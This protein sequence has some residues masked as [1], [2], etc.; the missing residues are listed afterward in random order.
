MMSTILVALSTWLHVLATIV[1]VGYY[2]F[3][4]LIF[5]PVLE[6]HMQADD[7]RQLLEQVSARLRPYFGGSLLIFVVSGTYLMLINKNYLGLGNFFA[8][9]WSILIVIKHVLVVAFLALAVYS[10]R[11]FMAQ[12]SV[13]KPAALKLF[14]WALGINSVLGAVI[15]LLTSIAQAGYV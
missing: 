14:R 15:I 1:M 5:L 10:E 7:L 11:A 8:N 6:R 4:G 9:P 13:Q 3:T 2:L 12:I